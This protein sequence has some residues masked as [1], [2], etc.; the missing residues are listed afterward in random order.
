M[1]YREDIQSKNLQIY[2]TVRRIQNWTT[3]YT[4]SCP[5]DEVASIAADELQRRYTEQKPAN[6]QQLC[7]SKKSI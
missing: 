2:S 6:L 3:L 4:R 7:A 1:N 5:Y